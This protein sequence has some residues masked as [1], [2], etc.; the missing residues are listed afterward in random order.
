MTEDRNDL[1]TSNSGITGK[2]GFQPIEKRGHQPI[3]VSPRQTV[4]NGHQPT[5][6]QTSNAPATPPSQGSSGK[7]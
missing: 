2:F 4:S 5:T 1:M 6:G 7:K 3:A